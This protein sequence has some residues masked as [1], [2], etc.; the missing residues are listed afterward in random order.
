MAFG[1]VE[2]DKRTLEH[3]NEL[4]SEMSVAN[5][6]DDRV[7]KRVHVLHPIGERVELVR[8]A[9]AIGLNGPRKYPRRLSINGENKN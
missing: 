3:Q 6:E 2:T 1:R 4:R 9:S 5:D 8:Y 7:D